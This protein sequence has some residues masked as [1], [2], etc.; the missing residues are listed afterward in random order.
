VADSPVDARRRDG[1]EG[2]S[3]RDPG[4]LLAAFAAP[5]A[6]QAALRGRL[7]D[8]GFVQAAEEALGFAPPESSRQ[9]ATEG[10]RTVFRLGPDHW[11]AV[12]EADAGFGRRLARTHG[13][14]GIDLTSAR[15]R[16][17]LRG[18]AAR[19]LLAVSAAV[20]LR[21]A[22]FPVGAFAQTPV[23]PATAILHAREAATFDI[24]IARSYAASW[25]VW[26]DY[27]GREFGLALGKD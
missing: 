26:L 18:D 27:A 17:R 20:D 1:F 23:G 21:P 24:Y 10:E 14:I 4:G 6:G 9:A 7:D 13:L 19:D 8:A 15:S 16:L 11:L 12:D 22:A 3:A 2:L 25:R 5:A